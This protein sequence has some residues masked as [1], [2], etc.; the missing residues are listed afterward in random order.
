MS[1]LRKASVSLAASF[2]GGGSPVYCSHTPRPDQRYFDSG[3]P[4]S[5]RAKRRAR[6]I[7]IRKR[8]GKD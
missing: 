2:V 1:G 4:M 7:I 8:D 5:K 3:K 6:G